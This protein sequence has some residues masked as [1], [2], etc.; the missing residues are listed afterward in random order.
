MVANSETSTQSEKASTKNGAKITPN[1]ALQ[2][3]QAAAQTCQQVGLTVRIVPIF[4]QGRRI[5]AIVLEGTELVDGML[6]ASTG[7]GGAA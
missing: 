2:I 1:E 4:D 3:L 7:T 5:T 6:I